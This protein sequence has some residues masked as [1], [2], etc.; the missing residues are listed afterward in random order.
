MCAVDVTRNV[1]Q[2]YLQWLRCYP[3][4]SIYVC[5]ADFTE[6]VLH[7]FLLGTATS[8]RLVL[9][10]RAVSSTSV[11][12]MQR[13]SP[14]IVLS[15]A[16]VY[17]ALH[18]HVAGALVL[19]TGNASAVCATQKQPSAVA[20]QPHAYDVDLG[21]AGDEDL[22]EIIGANVDATLLEFDLTSTLP[23]Q[24][25][26]SYV[27]VSAEVFEDERTSRRLNDAFAVFVQSSG[28]TTGAGTGAAGGS[29]VDNVARVPGV[30]ASGGNP[31]K[32]TGATLGN[33]VL[34]PQWH[35]DH[36]ILLGTQPVVVVAGQPVHFKLVIA[37]QG[38]R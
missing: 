7:G 30:P 16:R 38:D 24:V 36:T 33:L 14:R 6:A 21:L 15:C 2:P 8:A 12:I 32:L 19:S 10:I 35:H 1:R 27:L 9:P 23:G 22:A 29:R 4:L 17:L 13:V 25:A 5:L 34:T 28:A 11:P 18:C 20:A 37:D 3:S 31:G 26:L